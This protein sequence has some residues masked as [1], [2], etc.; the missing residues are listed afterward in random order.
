ML[1]TI[2]QAMNA[3]NL[4]A[5][6]QGLRELGYVEGQSLV[7]EYRS[8]DGREERF[9]SLAEELVR[10]KV[11][12]IVTRGT[13]ATRAA[14]AATA[15]IPIVVATGG[16]LVG[17]GLIASLARPGANIT[18]LTTETTTLAGKR[19]EL[20]KELMPTLSRIAGLGNLGNP[21]TRL[22]WERLESASRSLGIQ[23]QTLDVRKADDIGPA[24]EAAVR[25]HADALIVE[26]GSITQANR[27]LIA[28]LSIKHRLPAIYPYR[29]YVDA[30][31]LMCYGASTS[32]MYRRAAHYV[33]RILKGAK[34]ADL[35]VEQPT[36]FEL[37]INTKAAKALG[38]TI[39]QSLLLRADQ[40]IE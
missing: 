8:A 14:K 4:D 15:T 6:R 30:G 26:A 22:G 25:Q 11:D 38:L 2:P 37:V 10:L 17:A 24:F 34:P 1:E 31:G 3:D 33:D 16:D 27:Q 21:R 13:P 20:L 19:L 5:F 36:R 32:D 9:Q 18:G 23:F 39:P 35:P 7:I 12:L 28:A 40:L 29:E